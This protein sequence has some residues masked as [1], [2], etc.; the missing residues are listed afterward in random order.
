ML[1]LLLIALTGCTPGGDPEHLA[2]AGPFEFTSQEP[3]RDGYVYTR[4]QVAETLVGVSTAGELI[5]ELAERWSVSEDQL[6]WRF[7]L[8]DGVT[9]HDGT[10]LS[11]AAAA[12]ALRQ[13]LA[14]SVVLR[15]APITAIEATGRRDL[16][17]SLSRPFS[18]LPAALTHYST[19][20]AAPASYRADGYIEQLFGT[21]PYRIVAVDPPHRIEVERHAGHDRG[22][23]HIQR[24]SYLTGHRAESRTL[25]VLAGQTD[26]VYTLDPASLDPLRRSPGVRVHEQ[27]IP[28][29]LQLKV[30]SGHPYLDDVRARRA[31]SLALDRDGLA[32]HVLRTPGTAAGQL[33]PPLFELWHLPELEAPGRDLGTA[34]SLL[35]GLGWKRGADGI[36]TRDGER[37]ALT[38]MTY[39][40]RPELVV[41]ATAIQ[42]QLAELGIAITVAVE[43]SGSIPLGHASGTLEL[44]LMARNYGTLG[45]PLGTVLSDFG[46]AGGGDWGAMNWDNAAILPALAALQKDIDP[47]QRQRLVRQLA[48]VL[49]DELPV[50][51]V[52]YYVQHT[53]VA[54]RVSGFAFDPF[55][56]SYG[57][58]AMRLSQP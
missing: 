5:P 39:A 4:L 44:A 38:L 58:A 9:F 26:L 10:E 35:N 16:L 41:L 13:A 49:H 22:Q 25:Q 17:I 53:A 15:K 57:V 29:T 40:D 27:I 11:A 52:L 47:A 28:R 54:E 7:T 1:W 19:L 21:G 37:F 42:A 14:R 45:D 6:R 34:R 56:R 24:V 48:R 51:P 18:L 20:I 33:V 32:N 12:H 3:A 31:L 2:I 36:L 30:N 8:R 55:E 46:G 43:N 50:I 23:A